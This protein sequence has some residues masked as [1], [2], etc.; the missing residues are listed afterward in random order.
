MK[1]KFVVITFCFS[2]Q[3][4]CFSSCAQEHKNI[5]ASLKIK[6]NK[7]YITPEASFTKEYLR[8]S[9]FYI[10]YE[11]SVNLNRLPY[12]VV[13]TP[14]VMCMIPIIWASNRTWTIK[15]MDKDLYESLEKIRH[16]F[17]LFYPSLDWSGQLIPKKVVKNRPKKLRGTDHTALLFSGGLD[18]ICSSFMHRDKKQLLITL[19]GYDIPFGKKT[20]WHNVQEQC[21]SFAKN[22]GHDIAFIRF[23]FRSLVNV[24]KLAKMSKEIPVWIEYKSE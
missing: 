19:H 8:K 13:T 18:A 10:E 4:V 3:F 9:T 17:K 23:N 5:I 11:P 15:V 22:Y 14:F 24:Q 16:V 1:R 20:M 2:I 12:C 21:Y 6:N 7:L